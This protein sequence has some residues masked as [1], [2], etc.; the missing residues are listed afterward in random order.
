M[1]CLRDTVVG[2]ELTVDYLVCL[3]RLLVDWGAFRLPMFATFAMLTH[4]FM[5]FLFCS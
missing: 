2:E 3:A 1:V 4:V 5:I